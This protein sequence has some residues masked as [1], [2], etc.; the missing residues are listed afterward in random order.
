MASRLLILSRPGLLKD[1]ASQ[2]S[3]LDFAATLAAGERGVSLSD[4]RGW[5]LFQNISD[6]K[7]QKFT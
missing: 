4:R 7:Q 6:P 3:V 1:K 5:L 2:R